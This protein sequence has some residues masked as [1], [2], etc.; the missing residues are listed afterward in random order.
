[1]APA[2]IVASIM[3]KG[4]EQHQ[5]RQR[6]VSFFGKDLTRRSHSKC[7]L[8]DCSGQPLAAFELP[9]VRAE[10]EFARCIFLCPICM[11][12]LG[13]G[14]ITQPERWRSLNNTAWS[15]IPAVQAAAVLILR[16]LAENHPWAGELLEQLFLSE[17]AKALLAEDDTP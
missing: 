3:A 7:E 14:P 4:R 17:G 10:P 8:C 5:G 9:P 13:G 15:E 12:E 1:M 6:A 11:E 16:R 2:S